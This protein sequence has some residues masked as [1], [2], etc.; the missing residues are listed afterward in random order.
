MEHRTFWDEELRAFPVGGRG[1]AVWVVRRDGLEATSPLRVLL[2][3]DT[4]QA[5]RDS[6]A[7]RPPLGALLRAMS[8]DREELVRKGR[9]TALWLEPLRL[10]GQ[11]HGGL[12]IWFDA[13][14]PWREGIFLWGQRLV[15][16]LL[17]LL[18]LLEPQGPN[19]GE[20]LSQPTLFPVTAS[21]ARRAVPKRAHSDGAPS[22]AGAVAT[23]G[24]IAALR[25]GPALP[26][27][28]PV[29][30]PGIPGCVGH[31]AEMVRLGQ[32]LANI[33]RSGVNVLLRGESGTGKEIIARALHTISDRGTGPFI[34]AELRGPAGNPVRVRAVRAPRRRLHRR[35]HREEGPAGGRQRRH[36]LPGRDRRH[37]PGAADQIAAR[38]AGTTGAP[39]RRA[40]EHPGG[41]ALRGRHA[42]GSGRRDP[43]RPV[44]PGPVLPSQGG[45]HARSRPCVTDP[46]TWRRC[47]RI[48]SRGAAATSGRCG[49]PKR[50]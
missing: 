34:G 1:A 42:Q 30:V 13:D 10:G 5:R 19:P 14:E 27:P 37:A 46:R 50:P 15:P 36:L 26:L 29:T 38:D 6:V 25:L 9:D 49:S 41:P 21:P 28:R 40:Q 39:H 33:A 24:G 16:R 18:E 31:S 7:A 32:R 45:Q 20:T 11:V 3:W 8:D 17:P 35:R 48:S 4:G 47:S 12:A 2:A 22:A 44:P 43:R 23:M